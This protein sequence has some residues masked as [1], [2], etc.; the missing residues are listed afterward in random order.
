MMNLGDINNYDEKDMS[1]SDDEVEIESTQPR[2][3][4][5]ADVEMESSREVIDVTENEQI[6]EFDNINMT[7]MVDI[8]KHNKLLQ[9]FETI[10]VPY[11]SANHQA[12][13]F[14][15]FYFINS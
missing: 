3:S 11:F 9:F 15:L 7:G 10:A 12:C 4:F 5:N 2:V 14:I 13:D 1:D 8:L 6:I